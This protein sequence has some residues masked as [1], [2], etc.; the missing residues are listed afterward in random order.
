M[1]VEA[2]TVE[3]GLS[4]AVDELKNV[5]EEYHIEHASIKTSA[6]KL[7]QN[8]I[9]QAVLDRVRGKDFVIEHA[10]ELNAFNIETI[11]DFIRTDDTGT[12]VVLIDTPEGL[13]RIEDLRP[14]LFD[15]CDYISDVDDEEEEAAQPVRED[16]T[17]VPYQNAKDKYEGDDRYDEYDDNEDDDEDEDDEP[18]DES[19]EEK[20]EPVKRSN[21]KVTSERYYNVKEVTPSRPDHQMEI[22]EF[23]HYCAQYATEIDCSITGTSMLALYER[24]EL[25]E[26]DGIPLTK[27]N[28]EALIE[29]AADHAEKPPIGKRLTGMFRS[30][31]DKNGLLILNEED[32][33]N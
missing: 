5:H 31:Y 3:D 7:N 10:G 30:K 2:E 9:S 27:T 33:I 21:G 16:R 29:E 26:E 1:I 6:E 23:A 19:E 25:M 22:D 15:I 13:D 20:R 32:F 28:A 18:Y 4:I 17:P 24:I 11:Y 14:E 12:I 8:G